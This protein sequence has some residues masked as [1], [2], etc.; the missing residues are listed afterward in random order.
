MNAPVPP[1]IHPTKEKIHSI[2]V[3]MRQVD[4]FLH[5]T[6][7]R[8]DNGPLEMWFERLTFLNA[9]IDPWIYIIL[10]RESIQKLT[11]LFGCSQNPTTQEED[12]LLADSARH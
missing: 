6:G 9:I 3:S 1:L 7:L 5:A 12:Y 11:A 4:I 10:R 8:S 2:K